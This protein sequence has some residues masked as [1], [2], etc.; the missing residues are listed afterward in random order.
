MTSASRL[1]ASACA[2]STATGGG[3][4]GG[5]SWLKRGLARR[6]SFKKWGVVGGR[7]GKFFSRWKL[8]LRSSPSGVR[9]P[10]RELVLG[11]VLGLGSSSPASVGSYCACVWSTP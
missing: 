5:G 10:G 3:W 4:Y 1:L 7:G 6:R 9:V 11:V 8:A 2:S